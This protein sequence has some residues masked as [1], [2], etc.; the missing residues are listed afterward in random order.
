MTPTMYI[1]G[2]AAVVAFF[3]IG[4]QRQKG[5]RIFGPSLVLRKFKVD[6]FAPD[7]VFIEIEGRSAGLTAWLLTLIGLE[8]KTTM[9]VTS[10]E[11]NFKATTLFGQ[12]HHV[13]PLSTISLTVGGY[14]KPATAL[15]LALIVLAGSVLAGLWSIVGGDAKIGMVLIMSGII[16]AAICMFFYWLLKRLVIGIETFGGEKLGINFQRSVIENVSV[17]AEK[18]LEAVGLLHRKVIESRLSTVAA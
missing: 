15:L 13:V 7:G 12:L 9:R 17:D 10:T 16:V 11:L 5:I 3:V 14:S 8:P 4:R 2:F 6:E 18:T 1:L